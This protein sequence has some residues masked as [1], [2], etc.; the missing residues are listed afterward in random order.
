MPTVLKD[1]CVCH[2]IEKDNTSPDLIPTKDFLWCF[3]QNRTIIPIKRILISQI[4]ASNRLDTIA[5]S[6]SFSFLLPSAWLWR[7]LSKITAKTNKIVVTK[8][9]TG[10]PVLIKKNVET[11]TEASSKFLN[12]IFIRAKTRLKLF[13]FSK[14]NVTFYFR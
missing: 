4:L 3:S 5:V 6:T 8:R 1:R 10:F 9:V 7:L 11:T 12:M 13:K 2:I 14:N